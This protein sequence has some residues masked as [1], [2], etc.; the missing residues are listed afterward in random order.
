MASGNDLCIFRSLQVVF[1]FY[2][3]LGFIISLLLERLF[4]YW[5]LVIPGFP[6]KI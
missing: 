2:F 4:W 6:L 5:L 1:L 3:F